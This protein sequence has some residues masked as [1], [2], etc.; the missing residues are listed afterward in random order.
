[1][2]EATKT[3]RAAP[4]M[5]RILGSPADESGV[6]W[7]AVIAK[8]RRVRHLVPAALDRA[9]DALHHR[10]LAGHRFGCG[11]HD[12][13]L[14]VEGRC[15]ASE[16]L[17]LGEDRLLELVDDHALVR[18]VDVR[19][20][21]RRAEHEDLGVRRCLAQGAHERDRAAGRHEDR[22][23]HPTRSRAP[24]GGVVGWPLTS[25]RKIPCRSRPLGRRVRFRTGAAPRSGARARLVPRAD[26]GPGGCAC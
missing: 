6:R 22:V 9:Q 26:P 8:D 15:V 2:A 12:L 24:R 14:R 13:S 16:E 21:V 5:A 3:R 11:R 10:C 7:G 20:A 17:G 1:M 25:R 18:G 19:E 4:T 23:L